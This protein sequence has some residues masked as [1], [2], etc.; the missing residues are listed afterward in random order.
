MP[1]D[2]IIHGFLAPEVSRIARAVRLVERMPHGGGGEDDQ[3][4]DGPNVQV[5]YVKTVAT[6]GR[7]KYK[8]EFLQSPQKFVNFYNLQENS[9]GAVEFAVGDYVWITSSDFDYL[10]PLINETLAKGDNWVA[11]SSAVPAGSLKVV[12]ENAGT[13]SVTGVKIITVMSFDPTSAGDTKHEL[14][15]VDETLP[16]EPTEISI[17]SRQPC[18][19]NG[20]GTEVNRRRLSFAEGTNI[21]LTVT[22]G[23]ANDGG[24]D[25]Q[26][27]ITINGSLSVQEQAVAVVAAATAI[28]FLG[29][30]FAI[31]DGGGNRADVATEGISA[32]GTHMVITETSHGLVKSQT[33]VSPVADGT[34]TVG[35]ALTGKGNVG[36]IT[37]VLGLVTAVQVAS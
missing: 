35:A 15:V 30:D 11:A 34:Y 24:N 22:D 26:V 29:N 19:K 37:T 18:V 1:E 20:S 21:T 33:S 17:R 25:D 3:S 13:P 32:T 36:K 14:Q 2:D 10:K 16:G 23:G 8:G 6:A 12:Q 4:H 9:G 31:T 7:K 27:I 28:N 5:V